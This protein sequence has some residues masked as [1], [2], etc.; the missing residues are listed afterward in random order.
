MMFWKKLYR[1]FDRG[2]IDWPGKDVD[3]KTLKKWAA[4]RAQLVA[5]A[6]K[7]V[8]DVE[9]SSKDLMEAAENCEP[10]RE[11]DLLHLPH[12]ICLFEFAATNYGIARFQGDIDSPGASNPLVV[13]ALEHESGFKIDAFA[14]NTEL[15]ARWFSQGIE[16][17]LDL[18]TGEVKAVS[19]GGDT[20]N[21]PGS[22]VMAMAALS[23]LH[24][25]GV[26]RVEHG[27]CKLKSRGR[28][29]DGHT[30]IRAYEPTGNAG[31]SVEC[32]HRVRMHL[33]RGHIRRQRFGR[34][35]KCER[36]V[37]IKPVLVGYRE[38][39]TIEHEYELTK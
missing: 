20:A 5:M 31:T 36:K 6:Q 15:G 17:H 34:G 23:M 12:C 11:L 38:E 26:E 3:K 35:L 28:P 13:M 16:E 8:V 14:R 10:M 9:M 4:S 33:R 29:I 39:G 32:R 30:V 22:L 18:A 24:S 7:F 19:Y 25:D 37:W 21:Y 27:E 2:W 1:A